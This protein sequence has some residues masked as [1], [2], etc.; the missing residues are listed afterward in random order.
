MR[1]SRT[2]IKELTAAYRAVLKHALVASIGIAI[3]LPVMAEDV[4]LNDTYLGGK[5]SVTSG[6]QSLTTPT[7][8]ITNAESAVSVSG[9]GTVLNL[10]AVDTTENITVISENKYAIEAVGDNR[11]NLTGNNITINGKSRGISSNA[12]NITLSATNDIII[13]GKARAIYGELYKQPSVKEYNIDVQAKNITLHSDTNNAVIA[14]EKGVNIDISATDDIDISTNTTAESAAVHA[15]QGGVITIKGAD[16]DI[17]GKLMAVAAMSKGI[18][19]IDGQDITIK[20]NDKAVTARGGAT[21][22]INESE[23][24]LNMIG[25]ISFDYDAVTSGTPIDANVNVVLAGAESVWTGNTVI[26]INAKASDYP[27][28]FDPQNI[29]VTGMTLSIKDGATWNATTAAEWTKKYTTKGVDMTRVKSYTALNNLNING[30]TVNIADTTRGIYVDNADIKNAKFT[31]G[32]VQFNET[33]KVTNSVFTGAVSEYSGAV[34]TTT[35]TDLYLA[36]TVFVGNRA[37]S[38]GALGVFSKGV[39]E[40]TT[41]TK[42]VATDADDDGAGAV[43]FGAQS[44]STVVNSTFEYN[45]SASMGGAIATRNALADNSAATLDIANSLFSG[46]I[47]ATNGGAIY[48]TFYHSGENADAVTIKNTK[49]VA[50]VAQNGGAIYNDGTADKNNKGGALHLENV[51]FEYNKSASMGG[52]IYNAANAKIDLAGDNIFAGNRHGSLGNDIYNDGSITVVSGTTTIDGGI[53]GYGNNSTFTLADG[54]TL[55]MGTTAISQSQININGVVNADVLNTREHARL[56]GDIVFGDNAQLNLNVATA[57]TYKIFNTNNNFDAINVGALF[58]VK[59]NGA[60]GVVISTKKSEQLAAEQGVSVQAASALV[61]LANAGGK[62]STASIVAQNALAAGNIEYIESESVK[63]APVNKPIV[64]SVSTSVQNQILSLAASRMSGGVVGRSGGDFITT[65]SGMWAHGLYNRSKMNDS[66]YGNT[67]GVAFGVDATINRKYTF[68]MGYAHGDTDVHAG[69]R[70]TDI[71]SDTLFAYAQYKPNKWFVNGA[72][73]YTFAD[74]TDKANLFG[75]DISSEHNVD[76]YGT[77]LLTGYDFASGVTPSVGVRYLHIAQ[78]AY[79]NGVANIKASDT[80]F[81]TGVAGVKY[82]FDIAA[83]SALTLSPELRAAAT[84]DFMSDDGTATVLM[85]GAAAYVVNSDRLSRFSAEFGIGMSA[86]YRG[87]TVSLNYDMDLHKDYTS[88][89]GM[90]KFRYN[91]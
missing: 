21:V 34:E 53:M 72:F 70:S 61:G 8:S 78:D 51:T 88:Q 74:Y 30:G 66:F 89:T 48:N 4:N 71:D 56:L 25:D 16:V 58:D 49:F 65:G 7:I 41:F 47:A 79:S 77:Q 37:L 23:N 29:I 35:S 38:T 46:N 45:K 54:A 91:F 64:H 86:M 22:N 33:A 80:D 39:I 87:V 67:R 6:T 24:T 40:N 17:T 1:L 26:D 83:T 62:L 18:L 32:H 15:G 43:F 10:G 19:N 57:G 50:N 68:G 59:N 90:L 27:D 28:K 13:T 3:V 84:Y 60:D 2:A 63:V 11:V 44:Q 5:L 42:N 52:A 36:D 76:S 82:A 12:A 20:A 73:N 31:G 75:I 69:V 14:Y 55:N 85:P 81:L 9:T